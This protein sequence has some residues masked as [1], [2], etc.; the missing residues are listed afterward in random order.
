MYSLW[1]GC[2]WWSVTQL[3]LIKICLSNTRSETTFKLGWLVER[4]TWSRQTESQNWK[5]SSQT[6]TSLA[7]W[8]KKDFVKSIRGFYTPNGGTKVSTIALQEVSPTAYM[9]VRFAYQVKT[10]LL[11]RHFSSSNKDTFNVTSMAQHGTFASESTPTKSSFVILKKYEK[12]AKIN[13]HSTYSTQPIQTYFPFPRGNSNETHLVL[14]LAY[15]LFK[16]TGRFLSH[17]RI[18]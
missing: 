3:H 7:P 2:V 8:G 5:K 9:T 6:R 14:A 17:E 18:V 13:T 12:D 11:K 1:V 15:I 16:T 10:V 4:R